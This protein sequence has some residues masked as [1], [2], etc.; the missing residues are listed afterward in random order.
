MLLS[1]FGMPSR[2]PPSKSGRWRALFVGLLGLFSLFA[3]TGCLPKAKEVET[4]YG[5]L[6]GSTNGKIDTFL[7]VPYAQP[8]VGALRWRP[9]QAECRSTTLPK[10]VFALF[11][12]FWPCTR[13]E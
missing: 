7:N 6:R 9:P 1:S 3:L 11:S 10:I 4:G 5:I 12:P 13:L 8:P 2:V